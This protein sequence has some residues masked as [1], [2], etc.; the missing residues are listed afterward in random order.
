M[1]TFIR[2][3]PLFALVSLAGCV[4]TGSTM[5]TSQPTILPSTPAQ[6]ILSAPSVPAPSVATTSGVLNTDIAAYVDP[7]VLPLMSAKERADASTAQFYALLF[8]RP[9]AP[10]TWGGA[11]SKGSVVVGRYVRVNNLDCRDFT[12]T[13]TVAGKDYVHKGTACREGSGNW[14]V[15]AGAA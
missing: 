10:R 15:A 12:H 14:S 8:G 13:V 1:Q 7:T 2:A 6:P 3:L 9:G 4:G 5:T 11:G